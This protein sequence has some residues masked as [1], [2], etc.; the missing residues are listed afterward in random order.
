M[1]L[2]IVIN[3]DGVWCEEV[4]SSISEPMEWWN[5]PPNDPNRHDYYWQEDPA[6][7][8][9]VTWDPFDFPLSW[10]IGK[11]TRIV[12]G[13]AT[14]TRIDELHSSLSYDPSMSGGV[15][16]LGDEILYDMD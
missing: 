13:F 4:Y 9:P 6:S 10:T 16:I 14:T 5:L 1:I 2:S 15:I 8:W 12:T 3:S 11:E 7:G